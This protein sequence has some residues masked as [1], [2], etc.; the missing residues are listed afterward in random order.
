MDSN[1]LDAARKLAEEL[2]NRHEEF[3]YAHKLMAY[4]NRTEILLGFR[5]VYEVAFNDDGNVTGLNYYSLPLCGGEVGQSW[6]HL[7]WAFDNLVENLQRVCKIASISG[8]RISGHHG[9]GEMRRWV[10]T[11]KSGSRM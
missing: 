2:D 1:E 4:L 7:G 9:L 11:Q 5:A 6:V 8:C 3:L 10:K